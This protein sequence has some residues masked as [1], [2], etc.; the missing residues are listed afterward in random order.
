MTKAEVEALSRSERQELV[1]D[2]CR[3]AF[4][5]ES[6]KDRSKRVLRFLEEALEL[7][8]AEGG[9]YDRAEALL[10]RVYS[11]PPGEAPQE[12]G[13][14]CVTLLSYCSAAGLSLEECEAE[15]IARVLAKPVEHAQRRYDEKTRAGF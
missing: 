14:V 4:G 1:T 13:G 12:V 3:R 9:G 8:Q 5:V 2:W 7:F 15:E 11:R 6:Q 10:Q